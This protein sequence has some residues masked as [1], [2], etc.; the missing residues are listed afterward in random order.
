MEARR[1][2]VGASGSATG[3]E[4]AAVGGKSGVGASG[5]ERGVLGTERSSASQGCASACVAV[6]R[7]PGTGERREAEGRADP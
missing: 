3:G 1:S 5:V 7:R 6:Q 4:S 2:S